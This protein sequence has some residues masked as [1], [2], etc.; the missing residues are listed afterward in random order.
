MV[1]ERPIPGTRLAVEAGCTCPILDNNHGQMA[2]FPPDGWWITEA[3]PLH[4]PAVKP[5]KEIN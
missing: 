2:P 3:C 5:E 1:R 4:D